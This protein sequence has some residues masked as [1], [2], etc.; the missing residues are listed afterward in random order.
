MAVSAAFRDYI[1]EQLNRLAPVTARPMFGG[2][3]LYSAGL[4]FGLLDDDVVYFKVDEGNRAAF[5]AAGMGPFRPFG[6]DTPPM[7]YYEVPA[8]AVDDPEALAP[9]LEGALAAA[10]AARARKKPKGEGARRKSAA[11]PAPAPPSAP[12]PAPR[13]KKVAAATGRKP[14]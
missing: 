5:E 1:L 13:K 2:I 7:A 10:R 12:R 9:W 4:F 6:P 3:G 11:R 8:D 14:R